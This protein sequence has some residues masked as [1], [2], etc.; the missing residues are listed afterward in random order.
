MKYKVS[1][2]KDH[3]TLSRKK[4]LMVMAETETIAKMAEKISEEV[5]GFFRWEIVLPYNQNFDC[6]KPERHKPKAKKQAHTH[7]TDVVFSYLDSYTG[8]QVYLN[9]D[10][11]SYGKK[12]ITANSTRLALKSLSHTVECAK[13]SQEWKDRYCIHNEKQDIRGMLFVYNHDA[14][15][16]K[17]FFSYFKVRREVNTKK[18][19]TSADVIR[20]DSLDA[21][22][23][24][25]IH[26]LD[27]SRVNLLHTIVSDVK[28]LAG[29]KDFPIDNY[30]FFYPELTLHKQHLPD[31]SKCAASIEILCSAYIIISHGK[32]KKKGESNLP[33]GY[34]I[35]YNN[36]GGSSKEFIYFLDTLSKYQILKNSKLI[37]IRF[38]NRNR[39]KDIFSHFEKAIQTYSSMWDFDKEKE[40]QLHNIK[41]STIEQYLSILSQT[42]IGWER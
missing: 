4:E 15:Y 9:T 35:Y 30:N 1:P 33:E 38:T 11:K 21:K 13:V 12:S 26:I 25:Y 34:L 36:K 40:K 19:I 22:P 28:K 23:G 32:I 20:I 29:T 18:I 10:L 16:K 41:L 24:N 3:D 37:R 39:N 7:P 17:E 27:P 31:G 42:E 8:K 2:R 14:D 5:F 6:K